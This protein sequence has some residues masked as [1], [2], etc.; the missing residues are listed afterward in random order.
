MSDNILCIYLVTEIYGKG[1]DFLWRLLMKIFLTLG[2]IASWT[3]LN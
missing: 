3:D 1:M 2:I